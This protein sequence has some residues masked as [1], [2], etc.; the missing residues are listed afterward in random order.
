MADTS[1]VVRCGRCGREVVVPLARLLGRRTFD[2][3]TCANLSARTVDADRL[4]DG[5]NEDSAIAGT[6]ALEVNGGLTQRERSMLARKVVGFSD[7][8]VIRA[9]GGD[10]NELEGLWARVLYLRQN[11]P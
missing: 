7:A 9:F 8:E 5:S 6:A 1:V 10:A 4:E 2:C 3:D 11:R